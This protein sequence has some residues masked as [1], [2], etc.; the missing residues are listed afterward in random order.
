MV[1]TSCKHPS[2]RL[3]HE[4]EILS[5]S[6]SCCLFV[7][8]SCANKFIIQ[9]VTRTKW[10]T[11][12]TQNPLKWQ[13]KNTAAANAD[14]K[15]TTS[16]R[17]LII[18]SFFFPAVVCS[19]PPWFL[20]KQVIIMIIMS[21]TVATEKG[22]TFRWIELHVLCLTDLISGSSTLNWTAFRHDT[23]LVSIGDITFCKHRLI[24]CNSNL[25]R[26]KQKNLLF[27]KPMHFWM[28]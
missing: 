11:N 3:T 12:S 10:N 20:W 23:A 22:Q 4:D 28:A 6:S 8:H 7:L 21:I 1:G 16:G 17:K 24:R 18:R 9:W 2:V 14:Y 27:Q 19:C 5:V 25:W 26:V 15:V 13:H